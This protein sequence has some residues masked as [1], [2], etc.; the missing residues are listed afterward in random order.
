M[1]TPINMA[2]VKLANV[3]MS[4]YSVILISLAL[5][6]SPKRNTD[7]AA[8][9]NPVPSILSVNMKVRINILPD[10]QSTCRRLASL[11]MKLRMASIFQIQ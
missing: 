8:N 10:T 3:P 5:F 11:A 2:I 7:F 9:K 4:T 6:S 1:P